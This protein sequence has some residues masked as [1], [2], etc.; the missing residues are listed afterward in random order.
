MNMV[1]EGIQ[2]RRRKQKL[3]NGNPKAKAT[4]QSS[5][6]SQSKETKPCLAQPNPAYGSLKIRDDY[7]EVRGNHPYREFYTQ[8]YPMT[9]RPCS[10][11]MEQHQRFS[12][13]PPHMISTTSFDPV[14]FARQITHPQSASNIVNHMTNDEEQHLKVVRTTNPDQLWS[15]MDASVGRLFSSVRKRY[16]RQKQRVQMFV[17]DQWFLFCRKINHLYLFRDRGLCI[18]SDQSF[19]EH[20]Q[21]LSCSCL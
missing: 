11:T 16:R 8:G 21:H 7:L 12:T 10:S 20:F 14:L 3:S 2:T 15:V 9:D 17:M 18:T 13:G 19:R 4:K 1:K 6:N 5:T